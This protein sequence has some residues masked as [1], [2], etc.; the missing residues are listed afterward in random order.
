MDGGSYSTCFA[1]GMAN[2]V[3]RCRAVV[4]HTLPDP[5]GR[6]LNAA[7]RSRDRYQ[8]R[9]CPENARSSATKAVWAEKPKVSEARAAYRLRPTNAVGKRHAAAFGPNINK[10]HL[11]TYPRP[12]GIP[13]KLWIRKGLRPTACTQ[14]RVP[15]GMHLRLIDLV[16]EKPRDRISLPTVPRGPT[17]RVYPT[18]GE[19][20]PQ[21]RSGGEHHPEIQ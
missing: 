21:H 14:Y 6:R 7:G 5:P 4:E 8:P 2:H 10:G 17:S 15:L 3:S 12:G 16:G 1:E 13:G 19:V 20:F 18:R 11:R 9:D